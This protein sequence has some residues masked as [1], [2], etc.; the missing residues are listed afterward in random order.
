[1]NAFGRHVHPVD[2]AVVVVGEPVV[3]ERQQHEAD[4]QH[5]AL[6]DPLTGLANR[7][8]LLDRITAALAQLGRMYEAKRRGGSAPVPMA[9]SGG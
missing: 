4:L 6:H 8:L 1:M 3:T 5:R 2:P 7:A 9:P